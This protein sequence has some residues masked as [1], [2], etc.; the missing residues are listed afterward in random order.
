VLDDNTIKSNTADDNGGGVSLA[1]DSS[2]CLTANVIESN[3]TG[4][5]GGGV[6][7]RYSDPDLDGNII[8]VNS[9][10]WGGGLYLEYSDAVLTNTVIAEN[11][12]P[13]NGGG[14]GLYV[15]GSSP[16]LLHTTIADNSGGDGSGVYVTEST[17]PAYSSDVVLT[18]TILANHSV[19]ITVTTG[20][21][22]ALEGM[23]FHSNS[24]DTGGGG[25]FFG[26]H[27]L[28]GDPHF[29]ADGY[30]LLSGS[31]ALDV[32]LS[33]GVTTDVDG[34]RRPDCVI[35]DLGADEAVGGSVCHK[36]YLPAAL[37]ND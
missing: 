9:A 20:S 30:H 36:V 8:R 29:S 7:I 4:L 21:T 17:V 31:A 34:D 37:R 24:T 2:A 5:R 11:Q 32:G 12:A 22:A 28:W 27:Y 14:S 33:A 15:M 3:G 16:R 23:L 13:S 26:S 1:N 18:N 25:T 6:Y 35:P 19:G 10:R